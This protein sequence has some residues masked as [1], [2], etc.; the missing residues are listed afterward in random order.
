M[1]MVNQ[2]MDVVSGRKTLLVINPSH[3]DAMQ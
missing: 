1:E 2:T 3:P